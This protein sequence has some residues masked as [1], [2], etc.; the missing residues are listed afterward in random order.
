MCKIQIYHGYINRAF[1]GKSGSID[2]IYRRLARC[3][4]ASIYRIYFTVNPCPV[5]HAINMI[6]YCCKYH[7]NC[8]RVYGK[9]LFTLSVN[10]G[11]KKINILIAC[12]IV[13]TC[14]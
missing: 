10:I 14:L 8:M 3:S 11:A 9:I 13:F 4:I 1:Y 12:E 5:L 6:P 7:V 2:R